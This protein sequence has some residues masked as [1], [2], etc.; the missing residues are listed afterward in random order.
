MSKDEV[1]AGRSIK[2]SFG[3]RQETWNRSGEPWQSCSIET[4]ETPPFVVFYSPK[5]H[6]QGKEQ[7]KKFTPIAREKKAKCTRRILVGL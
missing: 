3:K 5:L 4:H 7:Y 1:L 2:G 6:F